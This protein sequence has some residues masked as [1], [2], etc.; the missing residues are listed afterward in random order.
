ML[1]YF[2][3]V[4]HQILMMAIMVLVG[5]AIAK[6]GLITEKGTKEMSSLLLMIVVPSI[7]ISSFQREFDAELFKNW[8]L[9]FG[10]S[11]ITYLVHIV[12]AHLIYRDKNAPQIAEKRMS[13]VLPNNGFLAF[14][15][16][17][18]LT[19][20]LGVF[21]GSTNVIILNIL[22]WTYGVKH[23]KPSEKIDVKKIVLNAGTIAVVCGLLLFVSPWKL[24]EPVFKAVDA[25]GSLNT[26]L[27]MIVLGAMLAQTDIKEGISDIS[28]YKLS[29]IKLLLCP[30][31]MIPILMALPVPDNIKIIGLIC[32]VTPMAAS[33]SMLSQMYGGDYRY[34]TN[35]VVIMTVLSAVTMPIILAAGKVIIGY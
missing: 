28:F 21:Y 20:E 29:A 9:M 4:G 6:A 14:P 32:S 16:M 24:P 30:I 7:I 23:L 3:T 34:A 27:A 25:I 13:I 35:A 12:V 8:L 11:A 1:E 22:Q 17:L 5:Y 18:A 33:V 19:G 31:I 15:L 2:L 10:I 26:P